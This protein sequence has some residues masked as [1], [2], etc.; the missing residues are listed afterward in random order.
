MRN[1]GELSSTN[2]RYHD[3]VWDASNYFLKFKGC[4]RFV[5]RAWWEGKWW[6]LGGK[7]LDHKHHHNLHGIHNSL[8]P[9]WIEIPSQKW[10]IMISHKE[11]TILCFVLR[12]M[13]VVLQIMSRGYN[14]KGGSNGHFNHADLWSAF[15]LFVVPQRGMKPWVRSFFEGTF[16]YGTSS[17]YFKT[18]RI[19]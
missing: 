13:C 1:I 2:A 17:F 5:M 19:L 18:L 3:K 10:V 15:L 4:C 9:A 8:F 14:T 11:E 12:V 16:Y 7:Q 6:R